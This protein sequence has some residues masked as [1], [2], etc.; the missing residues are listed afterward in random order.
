MSKT[1]V[2]KNKRNE[3]LTLKLEGITRGEAMALLNALRSYSMASPVAADVEM[4]VKAAYK[5]ADLHNLICD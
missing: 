2:T 1:T 3:T 5:A 4:Y